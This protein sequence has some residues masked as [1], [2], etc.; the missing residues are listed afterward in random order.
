MGKRHATPDSFYQPL[1][2]ELYDATPGDL[3]F[4]YQPLP[5]HSSAQMGCGAELLRKTS[6][7]Q[8]DLS[9]LSE[10]FDHAL[11]RSSVEDIDR[12]AHEWLIADP[13]QVIELTHGRHIGSS[14][15]ATV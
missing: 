14:L 4:G 2:C 6:Y 5:E 15:A 9:V 3:G 11:A 1:L 13:P 12:L 8:D 10:E 7:T